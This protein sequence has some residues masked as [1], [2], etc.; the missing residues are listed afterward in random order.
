MERERE[1]HKYD[2]YEKREREREKIIKGQ[3][4]NYYL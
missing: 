2:M 1:E 4:A 3:V